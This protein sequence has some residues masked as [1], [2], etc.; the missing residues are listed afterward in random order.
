[1]AVRHG[2]GKVAGADA[3]R[4]AYDT[5]DTTNS[6]IG[7]PTRNLVH[8]GNG[9]KSTSGT[10]QYSLYHYKSGAGTYLTASIGY[11]DGLTY[12]EC[13]MSKS[14]NDARLF[15]PWTEIPDKTVSYKVSFKY[16]IISVDSNMGLY[17]GGYSFFVGGSDSDSAVN[18][19]TYNEQG[20]GGG[21][22]LSGGTPLGN[23][24][25]H[26]EHT[27][28]ANA[29]TPSGTDGS[30]TG[31]TGNRFRIG[32]Y[33]SWGQA[34]IHHFRIADM[35][36]ER[37]DHSTQFVNGNR[38]DS[39]SLK[40]LTRTATPNLANMS[41]NS[42]AQPLFNGSSNYINTNNILNGTNSVTVEAVFRSDSK[43][44]QQNVVYNANGQGLYPRIGIY[45]SGQIFAQYRPSGTTTIIS[46]TT[47]IDTGQYYH[48]LFSYDAT[49]GGFLYLNGELQSSNTSTTG[50]HEKGTNYGLRIGNDTN[51]NNFM[52]GSIP[53]VKIYDRALTAGEAKANYNFYKARFNL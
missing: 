36:I 45:T 17:A 5:G 4:F 28:A 6:Y 31:G 44:S 35:Q 15:Y 51:L 29:F 12:V 9:F 11:E 43:A 37:K 18:Y 2:Y 16:K 32:F 53:V 20:I 34:Q 19:T 25:Y 13:Y 38:S 26:K 7:E 27:I 23:G 3:L 48:V 22:P 46:S 30:G 39:G 41:Y 8:F 14:L 52:S 21:S 49:D 1:M 47:N 24:W 33:G 10:D 50:N 42:N 40:D